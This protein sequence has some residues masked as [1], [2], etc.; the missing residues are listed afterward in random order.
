MVASC[1]NHASQSCPPEDGL[2]AKTKPG[3]CRRIAAGAFLALVFL[4]GQA[5]GLCFFALVHVATEHGARLR[6]GRGGR[7]HVFV[8]VVRHEV[9]HLHVVVF[10][11]FFLQLEANL[12]VQ[13]VAAVTT[14][15]AMTF[16]A[17]LRSWGRCGLVL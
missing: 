7:D 4:H 16:A 6:R 1:Y 3:H 2:R 15:R 5:E 11:F 9:E 10:R 17:L 8:A 13:V 12:V 14:G